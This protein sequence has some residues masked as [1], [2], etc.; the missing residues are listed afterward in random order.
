M[1]L[2]TLIMTAAFAMLIASCSQAD[3]R[4]DIVIQRAD[5]TR[6]TISVE[7]AA[8]AKSWEQGL[9]FRKNLPRGQGMLFVYPSPSAR[10]F[11][12]KNTLIP[13]DMLFFDAGGNLM[14][15]YPEA[16]PG[17]LAPVGPERADV[18]TVLEIGGGEAMRQNMNVGDKL[19]FKTTCR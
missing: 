1:R 6:V 5:G 2:I 11:W 18:C 12:M 10:M 3:D 17:S 16:R 13:L 4:T 8:D 7:I 19:I 14:F 15:V 9:M